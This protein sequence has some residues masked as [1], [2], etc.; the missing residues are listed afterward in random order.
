MTCSLCN[1][2]IWTPHHPITPHTK[3]GQKRQF[4][5]T[6]FC[7]LSQFSY[8]HWHGQQL[9]QTWKV[10][11]EKK[12][13]CGNRYFDTIWYFDTVRYL[14]RCKVVKTSIGGI[15]KLNSNEAFI[16]NLPLSLPIMKGEEKW[17]YDFELIEC[18]QT[19]SFLNRQTKRRILSDKNFDYRKRTTH[20]ESD[21]NLPKWS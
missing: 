6:L 18:K 13:S 21:H 8:S 3:N 14:I 15:F 11:S 4:K 19:L 2:F 20:T 17:C 5:K 16:F 1:W 9:E 12:N 7:I 10:S